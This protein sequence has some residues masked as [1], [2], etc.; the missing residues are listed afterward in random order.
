MRNE[1]GY[2]LSVLAGYMMLGMSNDGLAFAVKP[3]LLRSYQPCETVWTYRS[4][5]TRPTCRPRNT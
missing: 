1:V 2:F 3:A 5:M 4:Y